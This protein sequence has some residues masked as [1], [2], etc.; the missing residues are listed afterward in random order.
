MKVLLLVPTLNYKLEYTP[1]SMTDFPTGLAY[2]ASALK[3]AGHEVVGLNLN[4]D[5][6]YDSVYLSLAN[7]LK[8]TLDKEKPDLI[9]LGGLCIDYLF[10]KDAMDII[11]RYSKTPVVMG[12]GII[13]NDRDFIF[14]LLKPDF[15][16]WGEAEEAIVKLVNVLGKD[17]HPKGIDNLGYWKEDGA[18]F[19]QTNY[20]YGN[21]DDRAFPDYEPFGIQGMM[22]DYSMATRLLYR[23]TRPYARPMIINT[24][25]ACPFNCTFCVHSGGPKYRARSIPN[26]IAEIKELHD[27]YGFNVL[28]I[29]DELFAANKKRMKEFCN[30]LIENREKYGWDFDWM[31]QTHANARLDRET[32]ELAKRA[33]CYRFSYGI[34]SGS[35][36]VLESMNKKIKVSQIIDAIK[37]SH[38]VGIGFGGNLLF[39][40]PVETDKTIHE[41]LHFWFEHCRQAQ[42][43]LS[44]V[45]P[46]PGCK[47]FDYCV[48]NGLIT[49]K[50]EYYEINQ[51]VTYN[52]TQMPKEAFSQWMNFIATLETSWLV[53]YPVDAIRVEEEPETDNALLSNG[54]RIHKVFVTCPSCDKNN[55]YREIWSE[56]KPLSYIGTVCVHCGKRIKINLEGVEV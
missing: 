48:E 32:L 53:I 9:G 5:R 10:I 47:I 56:E 45:K 16:I 27:K 24:A 55:M 49:D 14:N 37:L 8:N 1:L 23:Y 41:T 34:E 11:R 44:I 52:M 3:N 18:V 26:I 20:D 31:F 17:E 46:Y 43:F 29:G 35:P 50:E 21:L 40:D 54:Q 38:E 25:R 39:G 15:C 7:R 30:A 12:G 2:I 51:R 22:D 6:K 4:N 19:N 42:V 33:G 13:N 28:I 36:K